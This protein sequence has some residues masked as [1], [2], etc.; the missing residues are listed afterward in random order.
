MSELEQEYGDRVEFNVMPAEVTAASPELM[1]SFG[2][3]DLKHGLVAF[4]AQGEA[5]ETLPGH[6]YDK[7]RI[8]A[9][10]QTI[11]PPKN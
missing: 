8:E 5:V 4:N 11:L 3:D 9:A 6:N 2:F 1:S 10:I 7:Y